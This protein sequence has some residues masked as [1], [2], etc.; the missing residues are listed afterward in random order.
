MFHVI[1]FEEK[2]QVYGQLHFSFMSLRGVLTQHVVTK[3]DTFRILPFCA[4]SSA[5][6]PFKMLWF[7]PENDVL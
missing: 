4:Y 1:S 3:L 6:I 5:Y 2:S 7:C